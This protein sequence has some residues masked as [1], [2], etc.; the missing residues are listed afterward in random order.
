M[1][2]SGLIVPLNTA[3]N[4]L[5]ALPDDIILNCYLTLTTSSKSATIGPDS[6]SGRYS[7]PRSTE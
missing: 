2:N 5:F 7:L 6:L 4:L 3:D 1:I